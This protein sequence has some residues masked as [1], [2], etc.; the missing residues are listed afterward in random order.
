MMSYKIFGVFENAYGG[1]NEGILHAHRI[2]DHLI[3]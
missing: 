3:D 2:I 1:V